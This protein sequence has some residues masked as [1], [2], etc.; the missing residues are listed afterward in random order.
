MPYFSYRS[1]RI[2]YLTRSV[3]LSPPVGAA[4]D[5]YVQVFTR[6]SLSK[7]LLLLVLRQMGQQ[8]RDDENGV[9]H[10]LRR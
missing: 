9:A 5:Q 10:I 3:S 1:C 8:V 2:V 7:G 4:S 6:K